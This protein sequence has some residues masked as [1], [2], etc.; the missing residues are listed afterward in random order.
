MSTQ[1]LRTDTFEGWRL[2]ANTVAQNLGDVAA[3]DSRITYTTLSFK[4]ASAYS[5]GNTI[6]GTVTG[7]T[8]SVVAVA[9]NTLTLLPTSGTFLGADVTKSRLYF[10]GTGTLTVGSTITASPSGATAKIFSF[11]GTENSAIVYSI[12]GAFTTSDTITGGKAV[13]NISLDTIVDLG[14]NITNGSTVREVEAYSFSAVAAVNEL[15]SDIGTIASL[16]GF[17]ATNLVAAANEIKNS[18]ITFSGTKTFSS[19]VN[20]TAGNSIVIDG[21][22]VLSKTSL[23]SGVVTSSLQSVGTIG[24]GTWQGTIISPAYGGTGVANGTRTITLNNG[25]IVLTTAGSA[26]STSTVTVPSTGTLATIAGAETLTSKTISLASNTVTGTLAQFNTALT[27][28]DF[29]ALAAIQTLTN[30]SIDLATNTVTGTLAQFNTAL[31]NDDFVG[32]TTAATISN[33]SIAL[34]SNTI[35]GTLAQF[36]AAVTD[37]DFASLDGAE[38]LT[39]KTLTDS[40]TLL[41][42]STTNS[43][44]AKFDLASI[45]TATTRTLTLQD[46]S[47]TIALL[48]NHLGQFAVTTSAQ[49]ASIL[50]DET[51]SGSVVFSNAP[52]LTAPVLGNATASTLN[53]VTITAPATGSTLTIADGKTLTASNTLT[54][55]GTDS[56]TIAFGAGGTVLYTSNNITALSTFSSADLAGRLTDETGSGAIVF[57]NS[58]SLTTPTIGGGGATFSGSTSGTTVFRAAATAGTTTITM[59]ATTG[60]MALTSDI[61]NGTLSLGTGEGI[62]TASASFTANQSGASS[63]SVAHA[64]PS[65]ATAGTL[66]SNGISAITTDKFGHITGVSTATF[67][68]S[69]TGVSSIAGTANQVLTTGSTGSV[70]LSLPQNIHSGAEPTFAGAT[71]GNIKIGVTTDNT[72]DTSTGNLNVAAPIASSSTV[73]I[74][75][76]LAD[77]SKATVLSVNNSTAFPTTPARFRVD[78]SGNVVIEGTLNVTGTTYFSTISGT[79]AWSNQVTGKTYYGS[80]TDGT[81]T[82]T[83]GDGT[84]IKFIGA[85]GLT[86]TVGNDASGTPANVDHVT[87]GIGSSISISGSTSGSITLQPVAVAGSNT[88]TLPALTGTAVVT[89]STN[90]VTTGM[91]TDGNVTN[92]K[93]QNSSVTVTAGSGLSG[94]GAVSLGGTVT[95]TNAG[96]TS[97]VAGTGIGVSAATGAVTISNSGV[98][99]VNSATGALTVAAGTGISVGTVSG[100]ITVSNTGVT[101]VNTF[102]GGVTVAAG[103]GLSVTNATGT[104][105]LANTGVLSVNGNTGAVTGIAVTS[106]TL[107]QFAATT[108]A[109]LAGVISDETGSGFLVFS[110]SPSLTTPTISSGGATFSGTTGTTVLKAAATASGTVTM[111]AATGTMALTSDIGNGTITVTAST[112]LSGSSSFT[113]NQSGNTTITLT[114]TDLG[115]SQMIFKN[116]AVSGQTTVAAASNNATLTLVAGSNITLTTDNTAKSVTIAGNAAANNATIT[117]S[118]GTGMTGG[119]SFTTDQSSPAT[120]TLTNNDRGSSQFIFKNIAVSGQSTVVADQ[121]DDTLTLAAG[122]VSSTLGLQITT[123]AF[124]DTVTFAHYDTSSQASVDNSNGVVIQDVTLDTYGHVTALGSVDLD[125]RYIRPNTTTTLTDL[126]LTGNLTVNGTTTAINTTTLDVVDLNITVAKNATTA[127]A[128][129]GSGLTFGSITGGSPT[130]LYTSS[131]DRIVF[132]RG[133]EG[134]SFVRTGG[135]SSQFLKADG[136]V[137]S[138]TYLTAESDTLATVTGRN[139]TTTNSIVVGAN[140]GV[141]IGGTP[142][143]KSY[144][145]QSSSAGLVIQAVAGSVYGFLMQGTL[146]QTVFLQELGGT[147][148]INNDGYATYFGGATTVNGVLTA[149]TLVKSGGTSS[150]FLKA[151]GS[152]D[153]N[154][155][156]TSSSVGNGTITVSAG[157]GMSGGGSFTVNQSGN[158]TVTLTNAG[159]TSLITGVGTLTGGVTIAG[160]TG[161]T[162]GIEAGNTLRFTNSGVTAITGTSNQVIA[163][164]STGSVTLSLPQ[165]INTGASVQF[166]SL[167]IG[168]AASGTAGEI[169][170]TDNV[171]AYY[172]SDERLKTNVTKIDNA[173]EK[174]SQIDGVIYDWNDVYKKSHGDVDGYFVREQNSGVIAQQVEK[175]FPNVV[176]DR[177]DGFKAVRYELLVPLLIEAIKDLKAEIDALK[178]QK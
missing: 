131:S 127:A 162:L 172:S 103:T 148:K 82:A 163:S 56:S 108:S 3:L 25:S 76:T 104:V 81:N 125:G 27:D 6:T 62:V 55:T 121:N 118:A 139:N 72:I 173:L 8:A 60:T 85:N 54:F 113:T 59:P 167:G 145:T 20:L 146:S 42:N 24:I 137:D 120:I 176:A 88:I 93:L 124:T 143:G 138:S 136:S 53:K 107:A 52:T 43:K 110:N 119:G 133:V 142:S 99:S 89:G 78:S 17:S 129:N 166:G 32:V 35:T 174:V 109:Q 30:K 84:A 4:G 100:T 12:T 126:T 115:S 135:T 57:A 157:T 161:L 169:R 75:S 74:T 149:T 101:A 122:Q 96:V 158:T 13:T 153:T 14:E 33:K 86:A 48:G 112:G 44:K 175:V 154:A 144:I 63:Y 1:V 66:G 11:D 151:D 19:S 91:I 51:G 36:N 65:G 5:A 168:T 123:D 90:T 61:G 116:I 164:A 21:A 150:Q 102:T 79:V 46:A 140:G 128:A 95:L 69:A 71:L 29:A 159:V 77:A 141:G 64:I 178:A 114:N 87:F 106:G 83:P 45:S 170:A 165:S 94:G 49:L 58:P 22:T 31:S 28:D 10:S 9:G 177:P 34:G 152:V 160:S 117:L 97:A 130:M 132:N 7:A 70:T 98:L 68:T 38:V 73:A 155:Y 23:G 134:S 47:G 18:S 41:Q 92:A 37:A 2:K 50:T 105:T 147:L 80:L 16:S 67:L 156:I 111:P 39:N 40:S 15:Q 26:G 171:T